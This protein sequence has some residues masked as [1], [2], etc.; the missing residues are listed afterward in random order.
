[1]MNDFAK[2]ATQKISKMSS[3][4]I[5]QLFNNI[6][7]ENESFYSV[8]ESLTLGLVI[9][10]TDWQILMSNRASE[11]LIPFKNRYFEEKS[12]DNLLSDQIWN[13]IDDD[14]IGIFLKNASNDKKINIS[15]EFV[16]KTSGGTVRFLNISIEPL[17]HQK[18]ISGNIIKIEDIT[19]KRNTETVIRRME[20]LSSLTNLAASVAH[21]IK[22]PLGS[23]SI[24]IQLL[25]KA[26]KKARDT[27]GM[28][29]DQKFLENYLEIVNQEIDR[30]NKI[31]VDFLFAV[32]PIQAQLIPVDASALLKTFADFYR[33]EFEL[34]NIELDINLLQN[35]PKLLLDEKLFK[36]VIINLM[37]N[38]IAAMA[39]GG[40]ITIHS[41][42][43]DDLFY[44]VLSDTGIGMDEETR[45]RIF[46]PYF[47]TKTNGTG[48]GL[49]MVYKIIKEFGGEIE[50]ESE[51]GK[52]TTF[53]ISLPVPQ[54]K[55][56][57]LE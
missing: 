13:F 29:P 41:Y 1:M 35:P 10:S 57:L 53:I 12:Q 3:S 22:N 37:Q 33:P 38:S 14:D 39:N 20:N 17:V 16:L 6:V 15:Q 4:Q 24:Y 56:N 19:E 36:Q 28:L 34:K 9:C 18:Q 40:K 48:L 27:D 50:V 49:T 52:G 42:I 23:I 30:L 32:R 8:I 31:I 44:V 7:D 54:D 45:Q 21:E 5:E 46:E 25:Q 55:K 51:L 47:T 43:K 26:I 11:R 2:K